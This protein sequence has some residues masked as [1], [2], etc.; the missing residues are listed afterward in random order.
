MQGNQL[1]HIYIWYIYYTKYK[2]EISVKTHMGTCWREN[3][4]TISTREKL[5]LSAMTK[6]SLCMDGS[7]KLLQ[8]KKHFWTKLSRFG[9]CLVFTWGNLSSLW[10]FVQ[11]QIHMNLCVLCPQILEIIRVILKLYDQWKNFDDR[12]E[13]AAVL[14]KMPKPKPPPNRYIS[15]KGFLC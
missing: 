13:I 14:N 2:N 1:I 7:A 3:K 9:C 6:T 11:Q 10:L 12:K 5:W 15:L 8:K 4:M